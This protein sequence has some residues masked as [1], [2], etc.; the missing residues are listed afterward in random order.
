MRT[1]FWFIGFYILRRYMG[2]T[3]ECAESIYPL[4]ALSLYLCLLCDFSSFMKK[5]IK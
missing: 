1:M 2:L 5:V 3:V 4:L